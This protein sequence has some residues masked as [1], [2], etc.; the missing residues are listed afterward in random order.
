M[1]D[2]SAK[3]YEG[4]RG[5]NCSHDRKEATVYVEGDEIRT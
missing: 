2:Q 3:D 4:T 1:T 5:G